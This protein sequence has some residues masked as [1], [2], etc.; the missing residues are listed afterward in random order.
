[1]ADMNLGPKEEPFGALESPEVVVV[2]LTKDHILD[3][4]DFGRC[5]RKGFAELFPQV[6]KECED[7]RHFCHVLGA[8]LRH[9][10]LA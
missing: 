7:A 2:L 6:V 5:G 10:T 9:E 1:M 3:G 4:R 8:S